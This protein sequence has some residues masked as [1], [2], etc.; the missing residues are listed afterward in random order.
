M[1]YAC[2][3]QREPGA[4]VKVLLECLEEHMDVREVLAEGVGA[5][6][7]L[8]N[9]SSTI[10]RAD[11]LAC[12]RDCGY[13]M[14]LSITPSAHEVNTRL[15][16]AVLRLTCVTSFVAFNC[17]GKHAH[18]QRT[19]TQRWVRFNFTFTHTTMHTH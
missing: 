16:R 10:A 8:A 2:I 5:I 4:A 3:A 9:G 14:H 11:E 17:A 1:E 15:H 7:E 18:F 19:Q 13:V 12:L 6:V